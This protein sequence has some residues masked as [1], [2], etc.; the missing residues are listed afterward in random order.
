MKRLGPAF[1]ASLAS[2]AVMFLLLVAALRFGPPAATTH[3][4]PPNHIVWLIQPGPGGGGGGGGNGMKAPP[5]RAEEPG[6]NRI[7]VP[8]TKPPA[9]EPSGQTATE[10]EP[11]Q[12]LIIPAENL[13]SARESLPGA[14]DGPPAPT[15]SQGPGSRGGAGSGPG[16]GIGPGDGIGFG[17]GTERGTG[18]RTYQPGSDVSMPRLLSDVKPKYTSD[19]MRARVQGAVLIGCIVNSKGEVTDVKVLRSLDATFGLDQ[20]AMLAA[21]Q[22]RFSPGR[23]QGEPVPVVVSIEL[24]FTLR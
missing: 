19:A 1:L 12:Q 22:W 6:R 18:G 5:R 13:A 21:R 24:I 8:V 7:T 14:I 3:A 17:P 23:R 4:V 16:G 15:L 10:A 11:I 2:H 20:E 9:F